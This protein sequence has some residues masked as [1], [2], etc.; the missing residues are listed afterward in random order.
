MPLACPLGA[1]VATDLLGRTGRRARTIVG[2]VLIGLCLPKVGDAIKMATVVPL[3]AV[4]TARGLVVGVQ[5]RW[6]DD[7]AALVARVDRVPRG[8]A[9]F[10]YPFSPMLPYLTGR[11][12]VAALDVM[13]PGYTSAAHFRETCVRVVSEAQWVVIERMW[14]DP[15]VLRAVFPAMRDPDPPEKRGFEAALKLGFD[16]ILHTST[17][18]EL[19]QRAESASV[20]LCDT[21]G[22]RTDAR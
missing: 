17:L 9:F 10:F 11:R 6:T 21:I 8:D 7:F 18:F 2:A 12:H 13:T 16:N 14:T 22:A 3:R 20:G 15:R 4:P 19:R 5:G 1:L